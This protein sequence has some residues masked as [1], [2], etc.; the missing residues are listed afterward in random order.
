MIFFSILDT[1]FALKNDFEIKYKILPDKIHENNTVMI[2]FFTTLDGQVSMEKIPD[3]HVESLD[4]SIAEVIDISDSHDYKTLVTLKAKTA[5]DVTLY[6]YSEGLKS[7]EIPLTIFGN[8]IPDHLSLDTFPDILDVDNNNQGLITVFLTD[9]N[10]EIVRA[11][12]DYLIKLGTSKPGVI[13]WNESNMII[14]KG[15]FATKQKFSAIKSGAVTITA[16]TDDLETSETLTVDE[17]PDRTIEVS[18]VPEIISSTKASTGNL[19]A[20]L[21]SDDVLIPATKDIPVFYEIYVDSEELN[22]SPDVTIPNSK[23]YFLIKKGQ[24]W[25]Y[26]SFSIQKGIVDSYNLKITSQDPLVVLNGTFETVETE[27]YGNKQIKFSPL[28]VLADGNR[29]LIG[30]LY[31][32]DENEHP[33]TANQDIVVPFTTSDPSVTIETSTIKQGF[34]S[35]LVYGNVGRFIPDDKHIAAKIQNSE[36]VE[37][38]IHG[39]SKESVSLNTHIFSNTVLSGKNFWLLSYLT[40]SDGTMIKFP[41]DT[42]MKFSESKIF[43]I[44]AEKIE[45]FPYFALIPITSMKDGDGEI[46]ISDEDFETSVSLSSV[47]SKPD[48]LELT[49]TEKLFQGI[50]DSFVV[51]ILNSYQKPIQMSKDIT[52]KLFSSDPSVVEF[53]K[54]ITIKSKSSFAKFPVTPKKSGMTEISL[55]SDGLPI[56]KK[57]LEVDASTPTIEITSNDVVDAGDSFIV[58][59][60]AKYNG[61]PLQNAKVKWD[62]DGGF[63]TILDEKTGPTGEAVASVTATSED[64][65]KIIASVDK[66]PIQSAFASK[67][68][69][70]NSTNNDTISEIEPDNSFE[71]PDLGGFDPVMIL[72]PALIGGM[73]FYMKK[74]SK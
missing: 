36:L 71:K 1:S 10:G 5:G 49:S 25:G 28:S 14:S 3:L 40:S 22:S 68:I 60:L 55:V 73:I 11:D 61:I 30:I 54:E 12:K 33:V 9:E 52:V 15:E 45:I 48:T 23:G 64:S 57:E 2:E 74:K 20:Q 46:T 34:D 56:V 67:I 66:G 18:V 26:H 27:F 35:S 59:A 17:S 39:V 51:Q 37:L 16:I 70:V 13:S 21:F 62:F 43:K 47:S 42:K 72:V 32:E 50:T 65:V 24:T 29:Q 53:P 7:L 19:I 4:N 44:D 63:S 69:Q 41:K 6:V 58:S 8:D 31:L 38:D